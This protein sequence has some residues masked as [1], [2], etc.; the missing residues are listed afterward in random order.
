MKSY[1][2]GKP[3]RTARRLTALTAL[4]IAS[5]TALA[6]CSTG[7]TGGSSASGDTPLIIQAKDLPT[8]TPLT[9]VEPDYPGVDGSLPGFTSIPDP[10]VKAFDAPP[11]NGGNYTAMT[12]LWGTIPPTEGNKYFE[13]VNKAMGTNIKFQIS[14]G[15]TYG[16]KL[17]ASLA[18]PKDLADWVTIPSW[19]A[20]PR[21]GRSVD[22]IFQ[23]LT[24][25]LAGDKVNDYPNLAN[26]PTDAWKSCSWNGKLYGLPFP[27]EVGAGNF[28]LYRSDLIK[29]PTLP[30]NA[31][32][33][34]QFAKDNT[35]D[36]HW[37]T[38]D[39]WSTATA[40]Y[41]VPNKWVIQDGKLVHKV[42]TKEYRDALEW[43]A[44]L[45]KSGAVHPDAVAD[46]QGD[47]GQRFEGGQVL[48]TSTG[49][50]FW[51]EALT[52]NRT[53]DPTWNADVLPYFAADGGDPI[54][55][56]SNGA[57]ICSYIKKTDKT[58]TVKEI[59]TAANFLASPFGTEEFQLINYGVKDL[60]YT[61]DSDGLP[62]PTTLAQTEVQP[63]YIFLVDPPAVE[64]HVS[65][66]E[67]VKART[68][69]SATNAAYIVEPPFYGMN[70]TEPNRF[71]SLD[72]PFA[73]L[74]KDI[75]RG[76]KTLDDLDAAVE[77]WRTSGG[78]DLREFYQKILDENP[79][80]AGDSAK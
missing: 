79:E 70:I 35:A 4:T 23:D 38:N 59:L 19:N 41:G 68:E 53:T 51:H 63:T 42:E 40:I 20:P 11:G 72:Q 46:N 57:S 49:L 61:L 47:A 2:T 31:E 77:T 32:E 43:M 78:N 74:E 33:L 76:R 22:S 44:K 58:D 55:Y 75:A 71:A 36:G 60:H 65:F 69:W 26:I 56:K 10:L 27:A 14:D 29:N 73:D 30:T 12:P 37:G 9:L 48:I 13:A 18:S 3:S 8:Y 5:S 25:Y 6:A 80:A 52:R 66:P 1:N 62:V 24:P 39:L 54:I 45:Y 15:N 28:A 17:A 50:G 21:F 16:E 64:A 67:Y 7:N 34:I